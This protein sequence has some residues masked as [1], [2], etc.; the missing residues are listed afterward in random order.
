MQ[1]TETVGESRWCLFDGFSVWIVVIAMLCAMTLVVTACTSGGD[2]TEIPITTKSD[3]ARAVFIEARE[4][5]EHLRTDEA[6]EY[7]DKAIELD[8][9]F[10]QAYLYRSF[11]YTSDED[12]K[13]H[14]NK[15]VALMDKVSEGEQLLIK[16]SK[17]YTLDNN[18]DLQLEL[19][20]QLVQKYP[21]DKRALNRLGVSYYSRDEDAK[22]IV[23]LEAAIALDKNYPPPYNQLGYAYREIGEYKKAEQTFKDYITLIP[24]EPNPYDSMGDLY[25]KIGRFEEAIENYQR[26]VNLD[27]VF[28]IAQRKIGTS[29]VLLGQYDE[30]REA[31]LKAIEMELTIWDKLWD[32]DMIVRSYLYEDDYLKALDATEKLLVAGAEA[33]LPS[34]VPYTHLTK[35]RIHFEMGALDAAEQSLVEYHLSMEGTDFNPS[36]MDYF[37]R[38]ALFRETRIAAKHQDFEMALARAD[39]YKARLEAREDPNTMENYNGLVGLIHLDTGDHKKSIEHFKPSNQENPYTLYYHGVAQSKAGNDEKAQ[40][41]FTKAANWNEDSYNFAFVRAKALAAIGE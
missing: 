16:Q 14:L 20:R 39:E 7:F 41:L 27:P 35:C 12:L 19:R 1:S 24:D 29:L 2:T 3:E 37:A 21:K 30:G 4:M 22:A 9:D 38:N 34:W 23:Q 5:S 11:D 26:A 17:A 33:D 32:R 31:C 6:R 13:I 36:F 28:G 40:E 15:A 8:P 25:M 10:A 18:L